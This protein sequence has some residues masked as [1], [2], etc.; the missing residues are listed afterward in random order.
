MRAER[1]R[2]PLRP[3]VLGDGFTRS[4]S[5]ASVDS[6][7]VAGVCARV[8]CRDAQGDRES[9]PVE[10]CS[11]EA[12]ELASA[13]WCAIEEPDGLGVHHVELSDGILEFRSVAHFDDCPNPAGFQ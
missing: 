7:Y 5:R 6:L 3:Y 10:F 9:W 12:L 13:W 11:R 8:A 4:V 1:R 2:H